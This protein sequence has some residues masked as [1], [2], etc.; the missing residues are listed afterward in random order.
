[1]A[2][3]SSGKVVKGVDTIT[4]LKPDVVDN[5]TLG[6]LMLNPDFFAAGTTITGIDL[7]YN[8]ITLSNTAKK[9]GPEGFGYT[10]IGS[11]YS[12]VSGAVRGAQL[13]GIDPNI[14]VQ[15]TTGML[16]TG[17]GIKPGTT[18]MA[19]AT[20]FKSVTLSQAANSDSRGQ[21]AFISGPSDYVASAEMNLWYSWANYYYNT[22]KNLQP[23][24]S[25]G[26]TNGVPNQPTNN[27]GLTLTG[28]DPSIFTSNLVTGMGVTSSGND[29][30][31]GTT[32]AGIDAV[33]RTITLTQAA[34]NAKQGDTFTFTAPT[35]L[36]PSSDVHPYAL[37]F[38][39]ASQ[40]TANQFAGVVYDV[41][42]AFSAIPADPGSYLSK[43][44]QLINYAVGCN[45]GTLA[46]TVPLP[47]N[48]LNQVRDELKSLMRGVYNFI[49]VPQF[50]PT[51]NALQWYPA[52][53]VPTTGASINN[54]PATFGVYNLNPFVWFVHVKLG[55]S[56][57]GFSVDDDTSN[58]EADNASAVDIAI[59]GTQGLTKSDVDNQWSSGS[60]FGVVP[61]M[62]TIN[63]GAND[64]TITNIN[65]VVLDEVLASNPI[66]GVVG[67]Y[68]TGPGVPA[69]TRIAAITLGNT[70]GSITLE[71]NTLD[72]NSP[73]G[74]YNYTFS[75][76]KLTGQ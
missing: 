27:A 68:I 25:T 45:I 74:T 46:V 43:S 24:E 10:F 48:R 60:P 54:A 52:P 69:N 50:N 57:Y 39:A 3:A 21:Y 66:T 33:N 62:G 18:I 59:G 31:A 8:S 14:G 44:A 36:M 72:K 35:Q 1:M 4:H 56:G 28:L 67:A 61:F 22:Y 12:K 70:S 51:T 5:L 15:L 20:D 65:L 19:I 11:Q 34:T 13:G 2:T 42:T 30:P 6:M 53:A 41:M 71:G 17:P 76:N 23:I 37:S 38:D 49:A 75:G 40:S 16:V 26:N 63:P 29:I 47:Q 58:V 73:A 55:M 9:D 7:T 32:I 64:T